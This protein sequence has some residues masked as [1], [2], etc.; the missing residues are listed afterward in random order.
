MSGEPTT[1]ELASRWLAAVR[2]GG[3]A[4]ADTLEL[5]TP[6]FRL[7]LPRSM[8]PLIKGAGH[9]L[10]RDQLAAIDQEARR[11]FDV[12]GS[13]VVARGYDIFQG[14]S[15]GLQAM[16][17]VKTVSGQ[18]FDVRVVATFQRDG[19]ALAAVWVHADTLKVKQQ[20]AETV[21]A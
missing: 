17:N 5:T 12:A 20:L 3:V 18:S 10:R 8:A 9:D 21:P 14:D 11:M 7:H 16:L 6:D 1:R 19:N 4:A 13:T 15:G 2:R